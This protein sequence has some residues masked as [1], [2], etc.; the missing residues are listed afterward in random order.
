MSRIEIVNESV[1][2]QKTDAIV[3][4]ANTTLMGGGGVDGA[5]HD[6]AGDRLYW[7]FSD[8]GCTC[9]PGEAIE[10]LGFNLPAK[11]II[12]TV[13]PVWHGGDRNEPHILAD[14]YRNSL[15]EAISHDCKSI[16]FCCISVGVYGYPLEP[17][18]RIALKTVEDWLTHHTEDILVRFCCYSKEEYETYTGVA[19]EL[20]IQVPLECRPASGNSYMDDATTLTAQDL[21]DD[22]CRFIHTLESIKNFSVISIS[23]KFQYLMQCRVAGHVIAQLEELGE[24]VA[25]LKYFFM[26]GVA[27]IP[28]ARRVPGW[29]QQK[30]NKTKP[31]IDYH[32]YLKRHGTD[33]NKRCSEEEKEACWESLLKLAEPQWGQDKVKEEARMEVYAELGLSPEARLVR[34]VF[35]EDPDKVTLVWDEEGRRWKYCKAKQPSDSTGEDE[36]A[37][38]LAEAQRAEEESPP[39]SAE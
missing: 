20:A 16:S 26:K 32:K 11:H 30:V 21:N 7:Y 18:T 27:A 34:H 25:F 6:A 39:Q 33:I 37:T 24:K 22:L 23:R 8:L 2:F 9:Q 19:K 15:D 1:V 29:T 38:L 13:G 35:G 31:P 10:S 3:N 36:D 14:C 5:I 12:H 4:A 28:G 17:A